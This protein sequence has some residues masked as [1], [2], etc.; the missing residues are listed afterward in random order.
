MK[1][2]G[3]KEM[4]LKTVTPEATQTRKDGCQ[5]KWRTCLMIGPCIF[6]DY[7]SL[8]EKKWQSYTLC[9]LLL[10]HVEL[11]N[12]VSIS[13]VL[14]LTRAELHSQRGVDTKSRKKQLLAGEVTAC[15]SSWIALWEHHCHTS[16]RSLAACSETNHV[17]EAFPKSINLINHP[18]LIP[19]FSFSI[20]PNLN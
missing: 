18:C 11:R 5:L 17:T 3:D 1:W 6:T 14:V 15:Q 20:K 10:W 4:V 12:Y 2:E 16:T 19:V 13:T 9:M 8:Q 7:N